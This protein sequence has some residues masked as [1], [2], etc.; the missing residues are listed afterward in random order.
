MKR[1][2]TTMLAGALA[3]GLFSGR[4]TAQPAA[5]SSANAVDAHIAAAKAAAGQDHVGLFEA[6]CAPTSI[7]LG[8]RLPAGTLPGKAPGQREGPPPDRSLWYV[9]P[10][11]VFDNLY[12]V[13]EK[14]FSSW[15]VVTSNGIIVIDAIYDYSVEEEVVGGL[16]KLGLDPAAIKYVIISH[17]HADHYAGAKF[18]QDRFHPRVILSAPDWDFL[19]RTETEDKR[20]KRDMVATDGM[21]LTLGDTTLTLYI[22]P[23]HTAGTISTLI[24]VK[25]G[26]RPHV[27]A[28]W[29]GTMFNFPRSR[30]GVRYLHRFCRA[31]PGHRGARRRR[32]RDLEPHALRRVENEDPGV[33][34]AQARRESPVRHRQRRGEAVSDGREG[35]RR[36]RAGR[37]AVRLLDDD[38]LRCL[39]RKWRERRG[40]AESVRRR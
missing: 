28:L 15:A 1:H 9:E 25:D 40:S 27:A 39:R 17:A 5:Q 31:I 11:K 37:P 6:A 13:G 21:K 8:G 30:A 7:R 24:P 23:G 3:V 33:G 20:P 35:M 19:E 2:A 29:G 34:G 14:E 4:P 12:F 18:L 10:A 22:T 16:K 38:E 26:G 32:H 36:R